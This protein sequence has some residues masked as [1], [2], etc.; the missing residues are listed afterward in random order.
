MGRYI[1]PNLAGTGVDTITNGIRNTDSTGVLKFKFLASQFGGIERIRARTVSDTG[2]WDTLSLA[3]R[4][5]GLELLPAGTNYSKI[6]GTCEHHGPG[7]AA[8]CTEP[9][10]NHWAAPEVIDSLTSVAAEWASQFPNEPR[11]FINDISI[12]LGGGLDIFGLWEADLVSGRGHQTHRE[13]RDVDI[14]T[15]FPNYRTGVN[16]RDAQGNLILDER[17]RAVGNQRFNRICRVRGAQPR[18][19]GILGTHSEH[20]HLDF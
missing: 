6:G 2:K 11:L 5:L 9:D 19:H 7:G 15:A 8:N 10:N 4:V 16:I 17:G 12:P 1:V 13:G 14:R 18:I 3:T 20:Y